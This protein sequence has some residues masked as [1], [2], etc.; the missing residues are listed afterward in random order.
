M[1]VDIGLTLAALL[2]VERQIHFP[3]AGANPGHRIGLDHFYGGHPHAGANR[4]RPLAVLLSLGHCQCSLES[5][6]NRVSSPVLGYL[7]SVGRVD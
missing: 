4:K 7:L 6:V 3:R 2:L 1:R 5:S